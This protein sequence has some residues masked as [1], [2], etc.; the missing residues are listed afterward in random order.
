MARISE[1]PQLKLGAERYGRLAALQIA[2]AQYGAHRLDRPIELAGKGVAPIRRKHERVSAD[3]RGRDPIARYDD[4][5]HLDL[6]LRIRF[7]S[8][9]SRNRPGSTVTVEPLAPRY[10]EARR[11]A[12]LTAMGKRR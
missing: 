11:A 4:T 8:T 10:L 7:E 5:L 12:K 2:A 9:G 1:Q 6:V 3:T